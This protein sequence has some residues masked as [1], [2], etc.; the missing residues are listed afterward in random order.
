MKS[1][2]ASRS[3]SSGLAWKT[4]PQAPRFFEVS[5]SPI[6]EKNPRTEIQPIPQESAAKHDGSAGAQKCRME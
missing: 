2:L 4:H 1:L 5:G 3:I 6:E